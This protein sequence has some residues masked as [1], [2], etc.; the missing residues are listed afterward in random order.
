MPPLNYDLPL[1]RPPAEADNLI[2][3]MILSCN[4]N[5]CSFC[6]MYLSKKYTER[7]LA[8]VIYNIHYST[9]L[10]PQVNRVFLADGNALALPTEHLLVILNE[11]APCNIYDFG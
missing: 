4:F 1:Y 7:T 10:S 8:E 11:S 5:Q 6:A 3:Q 9:T 2:I